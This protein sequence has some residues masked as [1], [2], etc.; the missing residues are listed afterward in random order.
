MAHWPWWLGGLAL[1]A[2]AAILLGAFLGRRLQGW[3]ALD[4]GS[5]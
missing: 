1:A 3:L 5:C 2:V 4:G